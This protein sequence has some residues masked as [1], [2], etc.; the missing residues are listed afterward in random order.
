MNMKLNFSVLV[1]CVGVC[2]LG[3]CSSGE[4]SISDGLVAWWQLNNDGTDASGNGNHATFSGVVPTADALGRADR[5]MAFDGI[6]DFIDIGSSVKPA[7]ALTVS[8]WAQI[9]DPNATSTPLFRNDTVNSGAFRYGAE[10]WTQSGGNAIASVYEGYSMSSNRQHKLAG[11][12]WTDQLWHHIAVTFNGSF[13]FNLYVDGIDVGGDYRGT[14]SGLGYSGGGGRLGH[15]QISGGAHSWLNGAMDDVRVYDRALSAD[16]ITLLASQPDVPEPASLSLL[17]IGGLAMLR[18]RRTAICLVGV[19]LLSITTATY[20]ATF[21]TFGDETEWQNTVAPTVLENFESYATGSQITELTALGV[22]F[23][24]LAGGGHPHIYNHGA[25]T[26][27]YGS[28]HLGNFPNGINATNRWDDIVLTVLPGTTITAL[29]FW[30][31]DGQSDTLVATAYDASGQA[32]GSVGAYKGNFAGF[33]SSTAVA[34]VVFD[35]NTGDGWNHLDGLQTNVP[36][37]ASLSLLA[38]GGLA[39]LRRSRLIR[40][41]K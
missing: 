28:R 8:L 13:D 37:P 33:L 2:I 32:L 6:D 3:L 26:T 29:G 40:R 30:N 18:R 41:R 10:L 39:M 36:E 25:N 17:A 38:I 19:V 27:P 20:A 16:E 31:G 7:M 22:S 12:V 34:K 5:A 23:E 9:N 14:G 21:D 15:H 1:M 11:G 4:A 35:G 24:T